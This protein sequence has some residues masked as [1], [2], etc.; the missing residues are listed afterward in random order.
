M[1]AGLEGRSSPAAGVGPPPPVRTPF[2]DNALMVL[3][4]GD[5]VAQ[6]GTFG[7]MAARGSVRDVARALGFPVS[8]GDR[9]SKMIPMGSQGLPMTLDHAMQIVPELK[10]A[11]ER[12]NRGI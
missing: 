8:I 4:T 3:C 11:Y 10:E 7:T 1:C 5:K 2:G 6:I 9:I 12:F